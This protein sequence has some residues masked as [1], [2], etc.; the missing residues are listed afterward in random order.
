MRWCTIIDKYHVWSCSLSGL[1][2]VLLSGAL[3]NLTSS[4]KS[5]ISSLKKVD[6]WKTLK[7][8]ML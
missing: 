7:T 1:E 8:E 5:A 3:K 4:S 6:P 2:S